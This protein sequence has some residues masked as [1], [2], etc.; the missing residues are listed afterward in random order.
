MTQQPGDPSSK[1]P[2]AALASP[3]AHSRRIFEPFFTG[4]QGG[5]GLGLFIARELLQCNGALLLY[6]AARRRRQHLPHC[7]LPIRS[8]GDACTGR[9]E[10]HEA[11]CVLI[12]DDEP[13]IRE[14]L[15]DHAR[16][17]WS[18]SRKTAPDLAS[19]P[20]ASY[21][22][23]ISICASPT[24]ACPTATASIWSNGF[25]SHAAD[26]SGGGDHGA[27]QRR[28]PPCARSSSAPS[29][30]SPSRSILAALRK[31]VECSATRHIHWRWRLA[32]RSTDR[33]SLGRSQA[34]QRLRADDRAQVSRSQAPGA[35]L[36]R[37][38][39][40]QGARGAPDPRQ[41]ARGATVRS[42]R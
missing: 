5:T 38:G 19:A 8:A 27:R 33:G 15:V 1:S 17:A 40:G 21:A 34:M 3:P 32:R 18:S 37:V 16:A 2:T 39:H 28:D 41:R 29:T 12:V 26:R 10:M 6:E 23:G 30:S 25:R 35:H 20:D 22:A 4:G 42:C 31:L 7:V 36:R 14:L 9:A 13:D 11:R 24:C